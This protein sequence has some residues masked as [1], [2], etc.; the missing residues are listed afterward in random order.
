VVVS[1]EAVVINVGLSGSNDGCFVNNGSCDNLTL[2]LD[3]IQSQSFA[4]VYIQAGRYHLLSYFEFENVTGIRIVGEG[5]GMVEI[6]CEMT[7]GRGLSFHNSSHITLM[8]LAFKGCG[9]SHIS[10]SLDLTGLNL[11]SHSFIEFHA[12]LYFEGCSSVYLNTMAVSNSI[13]IAVQFYY[14]VNVDVTDSNFTDNRGTADQSD[15]IGGGLY[16]EF[17]YCYPGQHCNETSVPFESISDT[18]YR[19]IGCQFINNVAHF[20]SDRAFLSF[21][22]YHIAFGRGAGLSVVF[23]GNASNIDFVIENCNFDGNKAVNGGGVYID[24]LD[25]SYNNSVT[26]KGQNVFRHNTA[27]S[28]GGAIYVRNLFMMNDRPFNGYMSI[29][30]AQFIDNHA[31]SYGGG[32]Y[33]L[34]TRQTNRETANELYLSD[35]VWYNNLGNLGAAIYF[36]DF[37][38]IDEGALKAIVIANNS[39]HANRIISIGSSNDRKLGTG[40]VFINDLPVTFMGLIAFRDT[41]GGTPLVAFKTKLVIKPN[42]QMIFSNNSAHNGGAI[43]LYTQTYM[44]L[45]Q[46]TSF[47]FSNNR[48]SNLGGAIYVEYIGILVRNTSRNCFIR[49]YN[50][51]DGPMKW[52][53][54]F[55]FTN[56]TAGGYVNS[57]YSTS[58]ASCALINDFGTSIDNDVQNVFCW[59]GDVARWQYDSQTST[60]ACRDQITTGLSSLHNKYK[61]ES[62]RLM[63]IPG[64]RTPLEISAM[65]D[66][67]KNITHNLVFQAFPVTDNI[68]ID[69]AFNYISDDEIQLYHLNPQEKYGTIIM[70]TIGDSIIKTKLLIEFVPC[71]VGLVLNSKGKCVCGGDF[72]NRLTCSNVNFKSSLLRGFWIGTSPF[73]NETLVVAQCRYCDYHHG[74]RFVLNNTLSHIN[75][76]L[77]GPTRYGPLCGICR[78]GYGPAIN[79]D[80][81][82]CSKCNSSAPGIATFI[83]VDLVIPTL[84]LVILS[85]IDIPLTSGI[86][87]GPIQF[88]QLVTTVISVDADGIIPIRNIPLIIPDAAVFFKYFFDIIYDFFNMEFFM[89]LQNVCLSQ[90]MRYATVILLH[91]IPAFVPLGFVIFIAI[92]YY[93]KDNQRGCFNIRLKFKFKR[94]FPKLPRFK[95]LPNILATFILLSYT[96]IA[97]ITGYLL[98]PAFLQ[99]DNDT[100]STFVGKVMYHDGSVKYFSSDYAVYFVL[101]MLLGVPFSLGI[102]FCLF[103]FRGKKDPNT[104]VDHLFRQFQQEFRDDTEASESKP[105]SSYFSFLPSFKGCSNTQEGYKKKLEYSCCKTELFSF[106]IDETS[107]WKIPLRSRWSRKDFRWLA[108]GLFMFRILL[109]IPYLV[110]WNVIVRYIFQFLFCILGGIAI[111]VLRPYKRGSYRFANP[112]VIEAGSM[113]ILALLIALSMYQYFYTIAD[114][115]LSTWAYLVQLLLLSIPIVWIGVAFSGMIFIRHG[116][117]IKRCC[118]R[119]NCFK[120][121]QRYTLELPRERIN[122]EPLLLTEHD[123]NI[124]K[125][126]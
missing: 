7:A 98:A 32:L 52:Q 25:D 75:D 59:N 6:D 47:V 124:N 17:P 111:L 80:Y 74:G 14:T 102:P 30:D 45:Y 67:Q 99:A 104:F 65:D 28:S 72:N 68:K 5:H 81:F 22:I 73:D 9:V 54:E 60:S 58:V 113:L 112:N 87:N 61:N 110:A 125:P 83:F 46:N 120:P 96:K 33:Y 78:E 10:T 19:I 15:G 27:T 39:F 95:N 114:I 62:H 55:I 31:T 107:C 79:L 64:K 4:T 49:Y 1:S 92:Y 116:D 119:C 29:R 122:T 16:I 53:T 56:N 97:I 71:P 3:Y 76:E 2:A 41:I 101:A 12:A 26:F 34:T 69:D 123:N 109:I 106:K 8:G 118:S 37:S 108:G 84:F 40:V 42:T 24:I 50:L 66:Q 57:I 85:I 94:T 77:C 36:T 13:G 105:N 18:S 115:P 23:K 48:A 86:F 82:Y 89:P 20:A 90:D 43:A 117:K 126:I 93:C 11:T 51:Y 103:C 44:E 21:G 91:Y 70:N 38:L 35:N 121:K 100:S 88:A 63:V